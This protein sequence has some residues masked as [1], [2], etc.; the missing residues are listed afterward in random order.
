MKPR[1][2]YTCFVILS[3]KAPLYLR[4]QSGTRTKQTA[5]KVFGGKAPRAGYQVRFQK[6]G[7][8]NRCWPPLPQPGTVALRENPLEKSTE[9]W[10]VNLPL[11]E[12]TCL[13]SL[14][15]KNWVY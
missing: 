5:R 7:P 15:L 6:S 3:F 11:P 14:W 4:F 12:L 2:W 13:N 9:L 10:S 1:I 8:V